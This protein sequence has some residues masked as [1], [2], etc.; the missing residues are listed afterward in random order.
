MLL[1]AS[2]NVLPDVKTVGTHPIRSMFESKWMGGR[3]RRRRTFKR[4]KKPTSKQNGKKTRYRR[5]F[6]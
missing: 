5:T 1:S 4:T 2:G 3:Q 6:S